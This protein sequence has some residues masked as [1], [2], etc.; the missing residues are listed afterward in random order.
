MALALPGVEQKEHF[1][2]ID[3]RVR[4]KVFASFPAP[5]TMTLRLDPEHAR[6]LVES[7]PETYAPHPGAWGQR[8][9]IRITLSRIPPDELADLVHES[10]SRLGPKRP[11]APK[12]N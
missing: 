1:G 10:W 9:W 8:G 4:N 3:F 12:G 5:D 7:E 6:L 11:A 2:N